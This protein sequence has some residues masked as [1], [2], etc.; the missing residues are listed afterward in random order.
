[1][2]SSPPTAD[3]GGRKG[4]LYGTM[5]HFGAPIG[6]LASMSGFTRGVS[7]YTTGKGIELLDLPA[8]LQLQEGLD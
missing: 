8:I 7:V 4:E 5:Q 6:I 2:Q 3:P 1:M